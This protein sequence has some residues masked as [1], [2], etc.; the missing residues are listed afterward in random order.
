MERCL[1]CEADRG[2]HPRFAWPIIG[3]GDLIF[4]RRENN[5]ISHEITARPSRNQT[6]RISRKDAKTK[7]N[8]TVRTQRPQR[9]IYCLRSLWPLRPRCENYLSFVLTFA[10][11]RKIFSSYPFAVRFRGYS[12]SAPHCCNFLCTLSRTRD[13]AA[14]LSIPLSKR[15]S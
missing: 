5:S 4:H 3:P 12:L 7:T 6:Q 14:D 1:A 9:G 13:L 2:R 10:S 15:R 11:L 8:F